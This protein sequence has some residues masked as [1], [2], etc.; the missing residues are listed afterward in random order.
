MLDKYLRDFFILWATID[1]IGTLG[2]FL[3]LTA[4]LNKA[5]RRRTAIKAVLYAA[6]ILLA[7]IVVGQIVLTYMEVR[8]ASFQV[9]GGAILFLFGLQMVFGR[10]GTTVEPGKEP[11]HDLAVFPLAIPSLAS[12]GAIMAVVLLTDN[13]LYS[14]PQQALTA[15]IMLFILGLTL[16]M[17]LA[18]GR[19][20][21]LLGQNGAQVMIRI[22][23]MVLAALA[24]EMIIQGFVHLGVLSSG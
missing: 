16:L 1:P 22:M 7:F 6:G 19:I 3:A 20:H 11:G 18:A 13:H 2:L 8:M 9:A 4:N 17:L 15:A 12:P 23:G 5:Q 21:R 24:V 14:I 10:T